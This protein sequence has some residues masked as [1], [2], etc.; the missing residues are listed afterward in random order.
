MENIKTA[1]LNTTD[2]ICA[3]VDRLVLLHQQP[4]LP[5][6]IM[7]ID[8]EGV[9]LSRSGTL[10]IFTLLTDR[11][12][13][14]REVC[15]I[16]VHTLGAQAFEAAGENGKTLKD[17]LQDENIPKV[18]F[19]V[20]NDSDALFAHFGVALKGVEDVP[21]MESATRETTVSRKFVT[22]LSKCIEKN[23]VMSPSA[24]ASWQLAKTRG[25]RMFRRELG[26]SYEVFN[27]RPIPKDIISY[28][29]GDVQYLPELRQRFW[30]SSH[31]WL[32]L[33]SEGSKQRVAKS[34]QPDY[35][36][37]GRDRAIAPWSKEQHTL[38]D[39]RHYVPPIPS[40]FN[41]YLDDPFDYDQDGYWYDDSPTSC[42][43]IISDCDMHLYYSD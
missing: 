15:L 14:N 18:F 2:E 39:Q 32:D 20:R 19:D 16:D 26:G 8:L 5:S 29:A 42:R 27:Q 36:P 43:D 3:L 41:D 37:H 40:Y 4:N 9:A 17:I 35:Q 1:V 28:C 13:P 34:Q 25:E 31:K 11:G 33:V 23:V 10:S 30:G 38:L 21:L 22:S 7:Y 12:T 24:K 6:P